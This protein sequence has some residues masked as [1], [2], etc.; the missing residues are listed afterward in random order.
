MEKWPSL[1]GKKFFDSEEKSF[2][3]LAPGSKLCRFQEIMK[4]VSL[5]LTDLFDLE[6]FFWLFCICTFHLCGMQL[7]WKDVLIHSSKRLTLESK[8]RDSACV[9]LCVCAR[10]CVCVHEG[11][12]YRAFRRFGQAKFP[13]S[14]S[15]LGL[16]Q[17]SILP[18]LPVKMILGLKVVKID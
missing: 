7:D 8:N 11:F 10:V 16:S 4:K 9:C 3:R 15:V 5:A 17:F 6:F 1:T 18:R 14:G 13:D 2:I 12:R